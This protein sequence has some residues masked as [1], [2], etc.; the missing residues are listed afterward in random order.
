MKEESCVLESVPKCDV[1]VF[2][3]HSTFTKHLLSAKHKA[4]ILDSSL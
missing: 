2:L 1:Y 4:D 3:I